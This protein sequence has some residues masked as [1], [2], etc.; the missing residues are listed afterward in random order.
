MCPK[1]VFNAD[2]ISLFW[3]KK[4]PQR[5][6]VSKEEKQAPELKTG[7]DKLTLLFSSNAVEFMIWTALIYKDANS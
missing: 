2:E 7:M 4:M 5:T 6:F 1:Y 3:K